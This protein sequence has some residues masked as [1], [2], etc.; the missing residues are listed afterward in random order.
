[1]LIYLFIEAAVQQPGTGGHNVDRPYS[2]V[3]LY[4]NRSRESYTIAL[5]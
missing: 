1:M 5:K 2:A 3:E 4:S